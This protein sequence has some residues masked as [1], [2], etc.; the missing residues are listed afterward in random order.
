MKLYKIVMLTFVLNIL[1]CGCSKTDKQA[2]IPDDL[3]G[4]WHCQEHALG[5]EESYTGYYVLSIEPDA[6]FQLYDAEA[7]NPGI[8]GKM[9]EITKKD[10]WLRCDGE[11]FDPP[12]CWGGNELEKEFSVSY[13]VDEEGVLSLTVKE[14]TLLFDKEKR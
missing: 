1:F 6:S 8:S 12:F 4:D 2:E 13:H 7:G 9:T 3:L 14:G 11:D 5:D 10:F